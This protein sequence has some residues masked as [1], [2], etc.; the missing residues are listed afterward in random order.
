M[1]DGAKSIPQSAFRAVRR[2]SLDCESEFF[3]L[4]GVRGVMKKLKSSELGHG[5]QAPAP[6]NRELADMP[7]SSW[8]SILDVLDSTEELQTSQSELIDSKQDE[9][10]LV[11]A[12]CS[13][14]DQCTLAS[15]DQTVEFSNLRIMG[16]TMLP[17]FILLRNVAAKFRIDIMV[18]TMQISWSTFSI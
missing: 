15:S 17:L 14:V 18:L 1:G 3:A 2:S 5:T 9:A 13:W 16:T 12:D 8:L 10:H 4:G 7:K 6:M 11:T